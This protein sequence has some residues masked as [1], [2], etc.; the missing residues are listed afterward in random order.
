MWFTPTEIVWVW[1]VEL[2]DR[3]LHITTAPSFSSQMPSCM[4]HNETHGAICRSMVMDRMSTTWMPSLFRC[5]NNECVL[6]H[7]KCDSV[8][9]C[10]DGKTKCF[11]RWHLFV[12]WNMVKLFPLLIACHF[13]FLIYVSVQPCMFSAMK[14]DAYLCQRCVTN[15]CWLHR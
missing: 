8:Q 12:R 4:V 13:V 5:Y 1:R 6:E 10:T 11:A 3:Y 15:I 14:V 7:Y 9:D 2:L